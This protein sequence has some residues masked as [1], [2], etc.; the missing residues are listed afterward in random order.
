MKERL[1]KL[2]K[3]ALES[4]GL[5]KYSKRL[6]D[7]L[8][9]L[10]A[11]AEY[12]YILN[13]YDTNSRFKEN[14]NNMLIV[15]LLDIV[16]TWNPEEDFVFIQGE[17]P[18]IDIDYLPE[19]RDH[20]KKVWAAERYGQENIC[21]IGTYGTLGIKSSML[22]MA[23]IHG[24]DKQDIQAITVKME[25]KDDE[26]K[27][28][29]WD[30][31]LE[32]YP[33]FNAYCTSH[34]EVAS[35]A[36]ML[37]DRN[38]SG[39]VHAGGLIIANCPIS[40]FVPLEVRSVKK[41]NPKG[42]IVSAWSEGQAT[43]DLQ[44]VGLIKFDLLVV[45][46]LKQYGMGAKLVKERHNL[47]GIC[48]HE[49]QL[50]WS[51]IAYLND[52]KAIEMANKADLK[53]IF[54][55]DSEG[56]RKVVKSGGIRC[57]DDIPAYSSLYRPGPLNMGMDKTF[58]DR[59]QGRET[60]TIKPLMRPILGNTYGVMIY[61]EQ[62]MQILNVVGDI[63]LIHCEK[64]R[65]AI[66]KKKEKEFIKYKEQFIINGQ[67]RLDVDEAFMIDLWNQIEAF[68]AYG[69]NKSHAYAYAY[70]ASR[71]LWLKAHY[72]LEFYCAVL[73]CEK[74]QSKIKEYKIDAAKHGVSING[75]HINKSKVEF[76]IQD[77]EIYFGFN[78]I[79]GI[80]TDIAHK[81]V[82]GQ[83]YAS[84]AD[85]LN[86]FGTES[87]VVKPLV[88]LGVFEEPYDRVT[89]YKFYEFFKE[90]Q[91]KR[92]DRQKRNITSLDNYQKQL[93]EVL[94]KYL[95]DM[96]LFSELNRFDDLEVSKKWEEI[97]G[98]MK[99]DEPYNYKGVTK[100][101]NVSIYTTIINIVKK[102]TSSMKTFHERESSDDLNLLNIEN[103]NPSSQILEK[104]IED[105]MLNTKDA[106]S[107]FY[108]FTWVHELE[109]SP[110]YTGLTF[111]EFEASQAAKGPVEV[112][113]LKS[114]QMKTSKKGN[115]Y[116][117][118]QVEDATGKQSWITIWEDDYERFADDLRKDNLLRI[119]VDTPWGGFNSYNLSSPK[120]HER[121]RMLPKERADD[122]RVYVMTKKKLDV[123]PIKDV[124]AVEFEIL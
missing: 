40:D 53:G 114:A 111:E 33:E 54:Q 61:Q 70:I 5:Q 110:N 89:L 106:E 87:K 50:D 60:Y 102:R 116:W 108:G 37:I 94:I 105:L 16:P 28:L 20:L 83:P 12:E 107:E 86:R 84:F 122:H 66:S 99:V 93:D 62:V 69:F 3:D 8:Y 45:N 118:M 43:Q 92:K 71:Q 82:E 52:K 101:R 4:K 21:S 42:V 56:I 19:V 13:L 98:T 88:S 96:S 120:K 23:K 14:E 123:V 77:D 44:P 36:K 17:F 30:K 48:C 90:N 55:F 74:D 63:P 18:D 51:D 32:M 72:P 97:F 73:A 104:S 78:K 109:E 35:T 75:V 29:E 115:Q 64:I 95:P 6:E 58:C 27:L 41:D 57:F 25:D 59:K 26:G 7:E 100:F 117:S 124:N 119:C 2:C 10:E 91:K 67:K 38:R 79:K 34:P 47:S 121:A 46:G 31:A 81:I 80:G 113:V 76:S 15:Y 112:K 103:F 9:E 65:K 24:Y 22:D 11:Q 39:G 68:A 85:F 49:G 1:T